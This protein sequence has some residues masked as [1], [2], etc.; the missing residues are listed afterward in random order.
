MGRLHE[1]NYHLHIR[2]FAGFMAG[3]SEKTTASGKLIGRFSVS[4]MFLQRSAVV[5]V[6]SFFFFL[7]MLVGFAIRSH[8]GYLILAAAFLVLHIFSLTGLWMLR[9]KSVSI[10]QNGL[11]FRRRFIPWGELQSGEF[12]ADGPGLLRLKTGE[13]ILLPANLDRADLLAEYVNSRLAD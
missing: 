5:A 12:P 11:E 7:A 8:T 4:P 13:E 2:N 10:F 3:V 1:V 9:T 6:L